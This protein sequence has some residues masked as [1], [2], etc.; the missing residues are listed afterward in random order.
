[1]RFTLSLLPQLLV[2]GPQ[3]TGTTA[4]STFLQLHPSILA[5][6][7]SKETFEEV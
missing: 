6:H 3:K 7:P 5:N 2:I 4:L 1:M